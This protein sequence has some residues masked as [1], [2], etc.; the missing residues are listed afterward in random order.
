MF[1]I[2]ARGARAAVA[3]SSFYEFLKLVW[4]IIV[5]D[6]LV[7]N[8]HIVYLCDQLQK[9]AELVFAGKPKEYDIVVNISPG[10]SKSTICSQA[11]QA[12][13]WT[14]M[15]SFRSVN[16]SYAYD[17]A[18][19]DSLACRDIVQSEFYQDHFPNIQLREDQNAKGL[20]V[21]TKRGA[22]LSASVGS[23]LMGY[24]G[25]ML[26]VDDP[27]DPEKAV[28]E[29]E[30]K[31]TNRWMTTTLPSRGI[32]RA[33]TPLFLIQQRLAQNDPSGER[34]ERGGRVKHICIPAELLFDKEG[35]LT[36][37]VQPPGLAK[38]YKPDRNGHRLMDPVR[39]NKQNLTEFEKT[40][41]AYGYAGQYLQDPVPLGG[42]LF[43]ITKLQ[44]M[45]VCPPMVRLVR[46]WDKA[47]TKDA[48]A[49]SA[50]VLLGIDKFGD[51]W[52]IDVVRGQWTPSDRERM[53][54]QTAQLDAKGAHTYIGGQRPDRVSVEI[55]VETEGGSGG[56]E[57][58]E[59]TVRNLSGFRI[60]GKRVTGEK[61]ERAYAFASQVGV[62][63]HVKV[64]N[65]PWTKEYISELRYFP[66]S[67]YKDQVDASSLAFNRIA[68]P[69]R[70][71]GAGA[72][73]RR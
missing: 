39:L 65:R 54:K 8:W 57:S 14:R 69:K 5:A 6:N 52:I 22:R 33:D 51:Y 15:P 9:M 20:F 27:I 40:L 28:S 19:K 58:T 31:K 24:H 12:W 4:P 55:L 66:H 70:I 45:E 30:L 71:I 10:S 38:Y 18:L 37:L 49:Y 21:N 17:V 68:K 43:D 26:F 41:G 3:R 1:S 35:K 63:D 13:C 47:A 62:Q 61:E 73:E 34:I 11:F 59:N 23:R 16:A 67:R 2:S 56:K 64:L 44:L 60:M 53:I 36:V 42:A 48:G 32:F 7:K 46:A 25:H 29:A 72:L 50:G